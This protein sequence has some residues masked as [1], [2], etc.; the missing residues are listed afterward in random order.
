MGAVVS[1]V[2]RIGI[3]AHHE[4]VGGI[5]SQSGDRIGRAGGGA[6]RLSVFA[7][8]VRVALINLV[9]LRA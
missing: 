9:V 4:V 7:A 2:V 1:R 8:V 3:A 6:Q 5:R